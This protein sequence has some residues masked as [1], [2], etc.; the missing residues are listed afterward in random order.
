MD[1]GKVILKLE[2]STVGATLKYQ[3]NSYTYTIKKKG[4]MKASQ[5]NTQTKAK[6]KLRRKILD[7]SIADP[8][9][10][11]TVKMSSSSV[12]NPLQGLMRFAKNDSTK[13]L[14][15]NV[16]INDSRAV[17]NGKDHPDLSSEKA[18]KVFKERMTSKSSVVEVRAVHCGRTVYDAILKSSNGNVNEKY[19]FHGTHDAIIPKICQNGFNRDFNTS[20]AYG[21]GVYFAA[22]SEYSH[23]YTN[24]DSKSGCR[25]MFLCKV[26]VGDYT[27]GHSGMTGP[28]TKPDGKTQYDSLVDNVSDPKIFVICKDYHAIPLYLILYKSS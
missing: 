18:L 3:R 11:N 19:L 25:G 6:R 2:Q 10:P 14:S 27:K 12:T 5:T 4:D 13:L 21:K 26:L 15:S 28:P 1:S 22:N 17:F 20:H 8:I 16:N 24:V 23:G 7:K 9:N